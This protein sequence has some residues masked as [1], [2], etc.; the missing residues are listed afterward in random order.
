MKAHRHALFGIAAALVLSA[1]GQAPDAA[2]VSWV[3]SEFPCANQDGRDY[4]LHNYFG[5]QVLVVKMGG[6]VLK[7]KLVRQPDGSL[8][9]VSGAD[10]FELTR[11]VGNQYQIIHEAPGR[12]VKLKTS[13]CE[14]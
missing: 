14:E 5:R 6:T 13:T 3:E 10:R 1:C 12:V 7:V 11:L 4:E 8:I 9:G 2:Q